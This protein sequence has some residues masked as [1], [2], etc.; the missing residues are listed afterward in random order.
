MTMSTA[1]AD[2][3]AKLQE[4][5][6]CQLESPTCI[7]GM[8]TVPI[9]S[10]D[11]RLLVTSTL[12]RVYCVGFNDKMVPSTREVHF[13]YIP[14]GSEIVSIDAFRRYNEAG[15]VVGIA[16]SMLRDGRPL[17]F[18][19][20]YSDS[21]AGT[22]LDQIAQ[23]CQTIILLFDPYQLYHTELHSWTG[24]VELIFLL[25]GGDQRIH[26]YRELQG[27]FN[28]DTTPEDFFP[29]FAD[30]TGIVMWMQCIYFENNRHRLTAAG[31]D[32]GCLRVHLV[33]AFCA[34]IL[35]EFQIQHDFPIVTLRIFEFVNEIPLP[36]CVHSVAQLEYQPQPPEFHLL[37]G[38]SVEPSVVYVNVLEKGFSEPLLLPDSDSYDCVMCSLVADVD[39]DGENEIILGT[40]GRS[41]V[42]YK[43]QDRQPKSRKSSCNISSNSGSGSESSDATTYAESSSLT[44]PISRSNGSFSSFSSSPGAATCSPGSLIDKEFVLVSIRKMAEPVI[45]LQ[46]ADLLSDGMNEI[47]VLTR[48]GLHILQHDVN[49]VS[50]LCLARLKKLF[51]LETES[52]DLTT[53]TCNLITVSPACDIELK[54]M[55]TTD[56]STECVNGSNSDVN[57]SAATTSA[58]E[59][60]ELF[61]ESVSIGETIVELCGES[62]LAVSALNSKEISSEHDPNSSAIEMI[63]ALTESVESRQTIESEKFLLESEFGICSAEDSTEPSITHSV[64]GSS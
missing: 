58:D 10:T 41:L 18:L 30:L 38:N 19:N 54:E 13:T 6:C 56:T 9:S 37:V 21:D 25:S 62:S 39:F 22:D 34:E 29:E 61:A 26:M 50:D 40:Y 46:V 52:N 17:V 47:I 15:I 23:G 42:V 48:K 45:S 5:H 55:I 20:V 2:M 14:G 31:L 64:S 12:G 28:E 63:E 8:T 53:E 51:C 16:F 32:N 35:K 57:K 36:E 33:D 3:F 4:V 24:D 44:V 7:Y 1:A 43:L 49:K 11:I 60:N 59:A 27:S